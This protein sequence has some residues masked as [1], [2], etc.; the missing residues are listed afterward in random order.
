MF[1]SSLDSKEYILILDQLIF[2]LERLPFVYILAQCR[3]KLCPFLAERKGSQN[4]YCTRNITHNNRN[5]SHL[6]VASD[7]RPSLTSC[8]LVTHK[9]D[10]QISEFERENARQ[11]L[12]LWW[13][14]N[15]ASSVSD[16]ETTTAPL[17][18]PNVSFWLKRIGILTQNYL[19]PFLT[20]HTKHI[21]QLFLQLEV[22]PDNEAVCYWQSVR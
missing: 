14:G 1:I 5:E 2:K 20:Y 18:Q 13:G 21:T 10:I 16:P 12:M 9:P 8:G 3:E 17:F 22:C 15:K 7:C 11:S 19:E 4:T 6:V